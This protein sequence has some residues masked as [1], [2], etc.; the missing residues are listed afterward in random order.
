MTIPV[1]WVGQRGDVG[2]GGD[3]EGSHTYGSGGEGVTLGS[4][5][6]GGGGGYVD[7]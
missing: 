1:R 4:G 7:G 2:R 3:E 6:G 5:V